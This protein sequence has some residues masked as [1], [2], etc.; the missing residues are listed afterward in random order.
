VDGI[1][2][3]NTKLS[4]NFWRKA[5]NWETWGLL[6]TNIQYCT[7]GCKD[8]DWI[9][10]VQDSCRIVFVLQCSKL[11]PFLPCVCSTPTLKSFPLKIHY[12]IIIP[13]TSFFPKCWKLIRMKEKI[14][15]QNKLERYRFLT[16]NGPILSSGKGRA[17]AQAVSRLPPTVEA[18]I[19]FWVSPC[20]ICG[21]QSGIGTDFS[22]STSVFPC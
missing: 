7:T 1:Y 5:S 12:N 22:L 9:K 18:R 17:M 19:R 6:E 11:H 2:K 3:T 15:L 20:G 4:L 14:R 8:G 13:S 16:R 21:G 10:L